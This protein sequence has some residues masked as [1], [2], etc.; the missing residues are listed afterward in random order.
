MNKFLQ[1]V[2][3]TVPNLTRT[4]KHIAEAIQENPEAVERMTL[5]EISRESGTSEASVIRF[6]RKLG[7][8]GYTAMKNAYIEAK[9][10]DET[11][12]I[13]IDRQDDMSIV[14]EK[15]FNNN[16]EI[17]SETLAIKE[18]PYE[19]VLAALLRAKSLNFFAVGDAYVAAKFCYIKFK[20]LGV[21]CSAEEDVMCQMITASNLTKNDVVIAVS[22][23][24]RSKNVV[25]AVNI[26]KR[27]GATTV[28]I[29]SRQE[30]PL[31]RYSDYR[32]LVPTNDLTVGR[33]KV[34]RRTAEQFI[35]EA[36]YMG[37]EARLGR[38]SF[39]HMKVTQQAIDCNKYKK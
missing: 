34:T 33:D 24:G 23:E 16:V 7:Y 4:E 8:S 13:S 27:R 17:L 22:Y 28:S 3:R 35:L 2:A 38:S 39:E 29:T 25:N 9:Q 1:K 15:L 6:C 5:A 30:S 18:N 26:A 12:G 14:L 10:D 31:M 36:L 32:L 21:I 19:E 37:Y 20:R 11:T